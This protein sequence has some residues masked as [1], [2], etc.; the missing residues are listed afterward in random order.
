MPT[1]DRTEALPRPARKGDLSLEEL[2]ARRQSRRSFRSDSLSIGL[3][4][5]ML[6]AAY[7]LRDS[8]EFERTVPSA[9]AR[10]PLTILACTGKDS[11]QGLDEGIWEYVAANHLVGRVFGED[12]RVPLA[13]AAYHQRFI[14]AAP[15][16][17]AIA[18]KFAKTTSRY[19]ERG[20]RYVHIDVGHVGQNIYLQAEG[21]GLGTVAVGAFDDDTVARALKLSP[22]LVPLYLMP[23]GHPA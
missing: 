2:L 4:S 14:A 20:I 6:W 11:I 3:L 22:P 17:I 7:G 13:A 18:A 12:V 16:C 23:V 21:L 1:Y 19:G 10:L 8:V 15:V 5:Q 9:G